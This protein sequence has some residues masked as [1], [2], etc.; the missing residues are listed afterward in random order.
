MGTDRL[1]V[2]LDTN[3]VEK[4]ITRGISQEKII[5]FTSLLLSL[6]EWV[7]VPAE[8]IQAI[9]SDPD[10]DPI[11]ACATVGKANYLVS[12]DPHLTS[13]GGSYQD[14]T[15]TEALPFLWA[16]RGKQSP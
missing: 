7:E 8:T 10:D 1:R 5:E 11:L 15:I 14:V 13:L 6:A 4:L 9:T 2:V 16:L 12:Y 3:V